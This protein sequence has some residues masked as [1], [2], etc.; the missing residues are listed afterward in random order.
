MSSYSMLLWTKHMWLLSLNVIFL[1]RDSKLAKLRNKPIEWYNAWQKN[2]AK[3]F[4]KD[5]AIGE[6]VEVLMNIVENLDKE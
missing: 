1:Q 5:R 2:L 6:H 4:G 3:F